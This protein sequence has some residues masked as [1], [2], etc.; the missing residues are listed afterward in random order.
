[1]QTREQVIEFIQQVK[2]G[3]LATVGTAEHLF[4]LY[5]LTP[6]TVEAVI[7]LKPYTVVEG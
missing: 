5:K 1:M 4:L 7:G 3:Y 2:F 6:E